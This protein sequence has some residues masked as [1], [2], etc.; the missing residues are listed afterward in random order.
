MIELLRSAYVDFYRLDYDE[1]FCILAVASVCFL[2]VHSKQG[3]KRWWNVFAAAALLVWTVAVVYCTVSSREG[4]S[5]YQYNLI[6]F[7][8]YREILNGGNPELYRSNLMNAVLFYPNGLLTV[9]IL[10]RKWPAWAKV[11]LVAVIFC[12]ISV[13]VEYMQYTYSLGRCEIDDVIHNTLGALAG[14]S[15][16][17]IWFAVK[18]KKT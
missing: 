16:A 11:L 6:P 2:S 14:A 10:P 7:H 15:A 8:S 18:T 5:A 4:G 12:G 3:N 1:L 17:E 13:G 9:A